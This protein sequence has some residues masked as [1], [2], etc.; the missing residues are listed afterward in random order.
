MRTDWSR[1]IVY[2]SID[3]RKLQLIC[4]INSFKIF[5]DKPWSLS[6]RKFIIC[7]KVQL[8]SSHISLSQNKE[9][10]K[11]GMERGTSRSTNI[12]PLK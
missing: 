10:M 8:R 7:D 9:R 4:E 12:V 3:H 2:E 6:H 5:A 1:A 11:T